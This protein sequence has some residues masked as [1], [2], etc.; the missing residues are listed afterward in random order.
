MSNDKWWQ[1]NDRYIPNPWDEI[2]RLQN[3]LNQMNITESALR[4]SLTGLSRE[5]NEYRHKIETE[6][7]ALRAAL[8]RAR[9]YVCVG[10]G[11]EN[12][13]AVIKRAMEDRAYIDAALGEE[14][15]P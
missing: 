12:Y 2:T 14:A 6:N 11:D 7:A 3:E 10:E 5:S 8:I 4:E 15:K 9:L 1:D 13:P